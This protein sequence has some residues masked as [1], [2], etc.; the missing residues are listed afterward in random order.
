MILLINNNDD[1]FSA[2]PKEYI[3]LYDEYILDNEIKAIIKR[4]TKNIS[5]LR[6]I[7]APVKIEPIKE[8]NETYYLE[9]NKQSS[10]NFANYFLDIEVNF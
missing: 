4:I 1:S 9:T 7:Q 3:C 8:N 5:N 10:K 2:R 6:K